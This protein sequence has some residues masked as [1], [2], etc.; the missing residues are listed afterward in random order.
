MPQKDFAL[1]WSSLLL[2][3]Y[4]GS[5][6]GHRKINRKS[7]P[8][9]GLEIVHTQRRFCGVTLELQ[10]QQKLQ[11]H[12]RSTGT[13][14]TAELPSSFTPK[15]HPYLYKQAIH[16]DHS[17][18]YESY[19]KIIYY[20]AHRKVSILHTQVIIQHT[21]GNTSTHTRSYFNTQKVILEYTP[22]HTSIQKRSNFKQHWGHSSI[23]NALLQIH[24]K[25]QLMLVQHYKPIGPRLTLSWAWKDKQSKTSIPTEG[26]WWHFRSLAFWYKC[27]EDKPN[28]HP[29]KGR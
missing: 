2:R 13:S 14:E 6:S 26:L 12:A 7:Y 5:F 29:I 4:P 21:Q 8:W 18:G 9:C 10:A 25:R 15:V 11:Y 1:W 3:R 28:M 20:L 17:T 27:L 23:R 24:V 19:H 16:G 22:C